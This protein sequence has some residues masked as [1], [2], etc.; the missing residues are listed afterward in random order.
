[1]N[2]FVSCVLFSRCCIKHAQ[3]L[4]TLQDQ[5]SLLN[6]L[7]L[8]SDNHSPIENSIFNNYRILHITKS[9]NYNILAFLEALLIKHYKPF[10]KTGLKASKELQLF[11]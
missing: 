7:P 5:F 10:L 3:F 2:Y 6:G 9:G 1:M 4:A 8:S 11:T